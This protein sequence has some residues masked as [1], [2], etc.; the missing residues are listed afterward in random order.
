MDSNPTPPKYSKTTFK[1]NKDIDDNS[2]LNSDKEMGIGNKKSFNKAS[3]DL[4]TK[5]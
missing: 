1:Q 5:K 4:D 2:S 3:T